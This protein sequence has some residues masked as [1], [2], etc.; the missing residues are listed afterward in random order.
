MDGIHDIGGKQGF[1]QINTDDETVGFAERWH[2][3]VFAMVNAGFAA[4]V[5]KNADHFRHA[6]E[7]IDPISYLTDG[8][9]GRWLGGVETLLVEADV[10]S[11]AE[12][13][14]Q[15]LALGAH[16]S[17]RIAARPYL[18]GHR[19]APE[20]A[21][22]QESDRGEVYP[23]AERPE[24]S[25]AKFAVGAEVVTRRTLQPGHTRLPAYARGVQGKII[26]HHGAWVYPDTNAHGR[27]EQPQHLYT[28][29]FSG[30]TLWGAAAEPGIQVNLDL[31]EAYLT[32]EP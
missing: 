14:A 23:T 7:R 24:I 1:G 26:A 25:A 17:A 21:D 13:T 27:G 9:Y 16:E 2:A 20:Q 12:V 22:A 10:V 6:I 18:P 31:F 11:Q 3:T 15:A 8:Y 32:A 5:A 19:L 29:A 28:V 4:G 30:G